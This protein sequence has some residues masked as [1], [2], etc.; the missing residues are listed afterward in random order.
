MNPEG[1]ERIIYAAGDPIIPS[2]SSSS[3][4]RN[5]ETETVHE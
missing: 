2:P 4:R 1:N 3:S 5:L